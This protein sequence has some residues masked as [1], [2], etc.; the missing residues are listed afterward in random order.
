MKDVIIYRR[1]STKE[2]GIERNGLEA[3]KAEITFWAN[4]KGY[5]IVADYEET[6]SGKLGL[7]GRPILRN[8]VNHAK[9][10]GATI[11]VSKLDRLSRSAI[12]ILEMMQAKCKFTV[13]SLGEDCDEFIL[14]MYAI[15]GEKERKMISERTKAAMARLKDKGIKVGG[16]TSG[17]ERAMANSAATLKANANVFANKIKPVISRMRDTGMTLQGIADE[18]NEQGNKTARGGKWHAAT[19]ANVMSRF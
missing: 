4:S 3:Q 14:H 5:N 9:E 17:A 8:A 15:L 2:Q 13:T 12:F 1:V 11:L 7:D 6:V 16:I 19:V 10:I 18:L